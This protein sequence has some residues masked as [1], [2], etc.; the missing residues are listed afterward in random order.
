MN[1]MIMTSG[2]TAGCFRVVSV[3]VALFATMLASAQS[4]NLIEERLHGVR[5]FSSSD[6]STQR[7]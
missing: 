2:T 3:V 4:V 7:R 1:L 5:A 6:R